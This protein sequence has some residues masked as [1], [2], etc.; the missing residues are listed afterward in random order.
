MCFF[1]SSRRRHTR[2]WR[3][4]SS[5]V[6]SSDLDVPVDGDLE[7]AAP[8]EV[9]GVGVHL[10][11]PPLGQEVR[12]REVRAQQQEQVGLVGGLVRGA[13]AEQPVHPDVVRVVVLDPDRKSTTS[14]L[15]SRQY[16]VCRL[17]L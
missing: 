17:L 2:Y 3:D 8:A 16:L 7:R 14:E 13:V 4:W 5:D 6:C 10:R 12:V 11:R 15:Q 9:T 1:F